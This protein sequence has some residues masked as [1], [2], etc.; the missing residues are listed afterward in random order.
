MDSSKCR[1]YQRFKLGP[2]LFL[3]CIKDL[4][5]GISSN[6]RLSADDIS[7][8]AVVWD[9]HASAN[10]LNSDL[11]KSNKWTRQW[12]M[13]FHPDPFKQAQ[14]VIFSRK[15]VKPSCIAF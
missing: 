6:P 14:E 12:E 7:I 3:I 2:L 1:S 11:V 15:E 10:N 9:V 13:S 4:S 5:F 8:F